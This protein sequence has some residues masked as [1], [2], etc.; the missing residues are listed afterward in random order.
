MK[1]TF[2][3]GLD[4]GSSAI[5][6]VVGQPYHD[7]ADR[8]L[9]ILA[10][11]EHASEGVNRGLIS[12]IDCAAHA[13]SA[14]LEKAER[15]SGV[16]LDEGIIGISGTHIVPQVSKGIVAIG[17]INGEI[18]KSDMDRALEAAR[19]IATP[20]NYEILHVIPRHA[21][22]DG[23]ISI[24][25]PIGMTGTRLE[26]DAMIIHGFASEVRNFTKCIYKTG[27]EI[28]DLVFSVIATGDAVLTNKQKELGVA[29]INFGAATTSIAVYEGGELVHT[30]VLPCG[31]D[32]ITSDIAIGLRISID[33]AEKI[34]LAY[35]DIL[36]RG[37]GVKGEIDLSEFD[38]LENGTASVKILNHIIEAR[39]EEL[40]DKIE[41]ELKKI[42]R[43]GLLPA[44]AVLIG[45]GSKLYGSIDSAK[46][47]L[48]LPASYAQL[49]NIVNPLEN[50]FDQ[51][52]TTAASLALWGLSLHSQSKSSPS[53]L[54]NLESASDAR[55]R[56]KKWFKSLL[57]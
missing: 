11:A 54:F 25:D 38:E 30:A 35:G 13:V 14:C 3:T 36:Q 56:V 6:I 51:S 5:R 20:A 49:R 39:V 12:D 21:T 10:A 23:Q 17:K 8:K 4:I 52:F 48:R 43:S 9:Q 40:F 57:P 42:G 22:I 53:F 26:V 29:L 44:G 1:E 31:S 18:S 47:Y 15:M 37:E 27:L 46:K 19:T 50:L 2:I 41:L 45:G 24:K 7:G 16:P 55:G 34:K 33:A 28:D 32:H